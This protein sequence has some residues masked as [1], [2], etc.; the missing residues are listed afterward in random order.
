MATLT[1]RNV[2]ERVKRKLQIRAAYNGRSMEAEVRA[3]LESV[4]ENVHES[5]AR[6]INT[7]RQELSG[8]LGNA[9]TRLFTPFN[10]ND[11]D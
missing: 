1:I 9:L 8:D 11:L 3:L 10:E 6:Q 4:E 2:D 5:Q 7:M